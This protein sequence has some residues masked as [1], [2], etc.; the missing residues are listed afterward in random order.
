MLLQ[1]P[2]HVFPFLPGLFTQQFCLPL[3]ELRLLQLFAFQL[4]LS[5]FQLPHKLEQPTLPV[6][7][8]PF[9]FFLLVQPRLLILPAFYLL[10]LSV[11][12]VFV[13]PLLQQPLTSPVPIPSVSHLDPFHL[14][15]LLHEKVYRFSNSQRHERIRLVQEL[16]CLQ[17]LLTALV[18]AQT[19]IHL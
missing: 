7:L 14:E 9:F 3:P 15:K 8:T 11:A 6:L 13:F 4:Q 5:A 19:L 12:S 10:I 18:V 2:I 17:Q 1:V 16:N